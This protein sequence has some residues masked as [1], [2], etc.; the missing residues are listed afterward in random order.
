MD[1]D[2]ITALTEPNVTLG[3][4]REWD[5]INTALEEYEYDSACEAAENALRRVYS[6]FNEGST[7]SVFDGGAVVYK[8]GLI[9][10]QY[11]ELA[12]FEDPSTVDHLPMAR[13]RMVF[14]EAGAPI[15]IMETV[16]PAKPGEDIPDWAVRVDSHQ[17]GLNADGEWVIFDAGW[18]VADADAVDDHADNTCWIEHPTPA[19]FA[20]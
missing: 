9:G 2:L 5:T 13:C 3:C 11:I 1:N 18:G 16:R 19:L 6:K 12:A 8:V 14:H 10:E 15:L 7:R 4:V 20:A 17:V